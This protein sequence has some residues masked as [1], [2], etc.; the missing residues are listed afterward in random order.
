[1]GQ[2]QYRLLYPLVVEWEV[3]SLPQLL[4]LAGEALQLRLVFLD[5][6][7]DERVLYLAVGGKD[8]LL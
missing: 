2:L 8:Q 5:L 6:V 1:M 7:L 3:V 4:Q